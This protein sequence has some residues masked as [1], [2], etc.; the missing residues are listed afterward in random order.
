MGKILQIRVSASTY[1]VSQVGKR[2]PKLAAHAW[3]VD[4][5]KQEHGLLELVETIEDKTR[6]GLLSFKPQG[7]FHG[8][9]QAAVGLRDRLEEALAEW[10][11]SE[12]NSL[13]D[14]LEDAIDDL[15]KAA[16]KV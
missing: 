14:A 10:R 7:D 2:W 12:A 5:D 16:E 9:L 13:S 15:E 1:D 6:L 8:A 11:A 3:G 4:V